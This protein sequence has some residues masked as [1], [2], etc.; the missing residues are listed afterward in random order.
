[1]KLLTKTALVLLLSMPVLNASAQTSGRTKEVNEASRKRMLDYVQKMRAEG[2]YSGI[3][4]VS[5]RETNDYSAMS[6]LHEAKGGGQ[7]QPIYHLQVADFP[8]GPNM[9]FQVYNGCSR[10]TEDIVETSIRVNGQKIAVGMGCA[11]WDMPGT[12]RRIYA[13]ATKQGTDF[14]RKALMR[15]KYV[16]VEFGQVTIPFK[17][18]GFAEAWAAV[19]EKAI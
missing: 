14:I 16:F 10:V 17:T 4:T 5:F 2:T 9:G 12:Y 18:D 7:K 13:I 6:V 19:N 1:M 3:K 11:E 8:T 15:E